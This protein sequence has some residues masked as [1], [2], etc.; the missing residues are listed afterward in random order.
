[1]RSFLAF[2]LGL[3]IGAAVVL[4][5]PGIHSEPMN[6]E[7]RQQLEALQGQLRQLGEQLKNVNLPK[8]G[9][10]RPAESQPTPHATPQ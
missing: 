7:V 4:F 8:P 6:S 9:E 10:N 3:I 1:M 5:V 2:L